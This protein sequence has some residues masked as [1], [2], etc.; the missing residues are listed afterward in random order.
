[1][2]EVYSTYEAKSRFSEIIRK[3][4]AGKR[5]VIAY[6]GEQIAEIRP[7]AAPPA[8]LEERLRELERDGIITRAADR[9]T[10][11]K[12]LARRPGALRRF[13]RSRD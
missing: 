5:I 2:S 1:M 6:R 8:D 10:A 4:R 7:L 12:P 3:V 9:R 11:W 13:L